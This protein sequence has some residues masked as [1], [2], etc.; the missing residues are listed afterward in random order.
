MIINIQVYTI[1]VPIIWVYNNHGLFPLRIKVHTAEGL[2]LKLY[3]W[4]LQCIE[5][6]IATV[7][8]Q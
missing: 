1:I 3:A 7:L 2:G 4:S 8:S 5:F 6:Q